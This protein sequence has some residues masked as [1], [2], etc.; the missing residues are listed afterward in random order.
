LD[1]EL[2]R[3]YYV[4][5]KLTFQ[6]FVGAEIGWIKEK[7]YGIYKTYL[8]DNTVIDSYAESKSWLLGPRVG[9]DTAWLLGEGF[10]FFVNSAFSIFYQDFDNKRNFDIAPGQTIPA[11]I[12]T[13]KHKHRGVNSHFEAALGFGWGTYF[14]D[15]EWH[16]DLSAG[17]EF[18]LLTDQ[19]VLHDLE[20][21]ESGRKIPLGENLTGKDHYLHGLTVTARV[22][23]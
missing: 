23:F 19:Y 4:G 13:Y 5:T 8:Y 18:H 17:Y 9:I 10:R 14:S 6:P 12:F 16:L 1:F 20:D 2:S 11:Q 21:G 3:A 7:V 15:N 22:D